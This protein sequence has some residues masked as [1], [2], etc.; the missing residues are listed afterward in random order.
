MA[1]AIQPNLLIYPICHA[2]Q[3]Q[4]TQRD[5]ITEAIKAFGYRFHFG[6][7][8]NLALSKAPEQL[9]GRNVDQF[10]FVRLIEDEVRD[11]R[12]EADRRNLADDIAQAFKVLNIQRG[13]N[14]DARVEQF[15]NVLPAPGMARPR[16]ISMRQ[17][18][19][20]NE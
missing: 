5:Q 1:L 12:R 3:G 17:I 11:R 9:F 16:H 18:I 15:L 19:D 6:R 10:N 14:V 4:F 7:N 8:V 20:Q 13:V 2:A